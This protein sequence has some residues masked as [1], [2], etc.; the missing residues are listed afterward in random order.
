MEVHHPHHPTHKKNWKEYITE[1]IMLVSA[2]SLGF[3]AE[4][5]REQYIEKERAHELISRFQVDVKNNVYFLDSLLTFNNNM[6]YQMDTALFELFHAKDKYDLNFFF[7]NVKASFPRF[8]SKNDTYEQMKSSGY[9]RYIKDEQLLTMMIDYTNETEGAE[10]RSKEQEANYALGEYANILSRWTP[11][12]IALKYHVKS[13]TNMISR[14]QSNDSTINLMRK[15]EYINV[16]KPHIIKGV[17]LDNFKKEIIPAMTRRM[18]L[19]KTT[20]SYLKKSSQK[21]ELLL[22]YLNHKH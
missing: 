16:E 20:M 15:M 6:E 11:S 12:E 22:E 10:Y 14:I 8:L 2:V 1:F 4:N 9:L 3:L 7:T 18:G 17:E 5:I 21:G 19:M 13:F